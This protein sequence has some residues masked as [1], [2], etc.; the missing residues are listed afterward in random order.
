MRILKHLVK[1]ASAKSKSLFCKHPELESSSCPF[2]GLTY[3]YCKACMKKM[4][5]RRTND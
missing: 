3:T 4:N 2:T 5:T 1:V